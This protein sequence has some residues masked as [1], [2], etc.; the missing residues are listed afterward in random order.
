MLAIRSWSL[1]VAIFLPVS[2]PS[3]AEEDLGS[4]VFPFHGGDKKLFLHLLSIKAIDI[5]SLRHGSAAMN[6]AYGSLHSLGAAV[7]DDAVRGGP[8]DALEELSCGSIPEAMLEEGRKIYLA[9]RISDRQSVNRGARQYGGVQLPLGPLVVIFPITVSA[10]VVAIL[11][12]P[13][14]ELEGFLEGG[15]ILEQ[16]TEHPVSREGLFHHIGV[17]GPAEKIVSVSHDRSSPR[18]S[19]DV[20]RLAF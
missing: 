1:I 13:F 17:S 19:F 6:L 4:S 5:S 20:L 16:N 14:D 2:V 10:Y 8:L 12:R 7:N 11:Q 18:D 15:K 3:P 9:A